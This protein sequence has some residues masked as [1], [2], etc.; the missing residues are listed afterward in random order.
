MSR[1]IVS[2]DK[3]KEGF[4][5]Y[6]KFKDKEQFVIAA[7]SLDDI[8]GLLSKLKNKDGNYSIV[9]FNNR[10][11]FKELLNN[12]DKLVEFR[13]LNIFFV[14][15]F[16]NLDKRWIIYPHTH[17]KICDKESLEKGLKT[18]FDMVEPLSEESIKNKF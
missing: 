5:V 17:N 1:S 15:P 9:T 11:N 10:N 2:I 4:D 6:V 12:W 13:L 3:N 14:N 7:P 8:N 16:S 18:M